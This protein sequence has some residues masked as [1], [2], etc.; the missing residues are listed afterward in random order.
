MR[1]RAW[2]L[3]MKMVSELERELA[4]PDPTQKLTRTGLMRRATV[5][6]NKARL[7]GATQFANDLG[8]LTEEQRSELRQRLAALM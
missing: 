7:D 2:S 3:L 4:S 6:G 5:D 1:D 8:L